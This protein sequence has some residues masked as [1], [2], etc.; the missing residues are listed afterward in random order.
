MNMDR[1]LILLAFKTAGLRTLV[2]G[3]WYPAFTVP[4]LHY[5]MTTRQAMVRNL[6]KINR[7]LVNNI[8]FSQQHRLRSFDVKIYVT[9][10]AP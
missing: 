6:W 3:T 7:I 8:E 10:L 1:V 4:I 9:P 2:S 5:Q